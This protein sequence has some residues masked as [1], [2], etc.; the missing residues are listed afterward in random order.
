MEAY[1]PHRLLRSQTFTA[2]GTSDKTV[3]GPNPRRWALIISVSGPVGAQ[4][5]SDAAVAQAQS[6]AAAGIILTY[7]VPAGVTATLDVAGFVSDAVGGQVAGLYVNRVGGVGNILFLQGT[8][9]ANFSGKLLLGPGDKVLWNVITPVAASTADF[10]LLLTLTPQSFRTTLSFIGPAIQDQGLTLYPG[11]KPII[12]LYDH[13]GQAL[14]EEIHAI[15]PQVGATIE[16]I[17]I[18]LGKE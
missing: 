11:N 4:G 2:L 17:E 10:S 8:T 3:L 13:I 1:K 16:I 7:T 5:K 9:Q 18:F 15:A 6:T 14:R 12:L